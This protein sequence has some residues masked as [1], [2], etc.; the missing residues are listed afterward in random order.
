[1]EGTRRSRYPPSRD[2]LFPQGG[3]RR[4]FESV[5]VAKIAVVCGACGATRVGRQGRRV[6]GRRNENGPRCAERAGGDTGRT[7][8]GRQTE[9]RQATV[10]KN[11]PTGYLSSGG[12]EL[13]RWMQWC[14]GIVVGSVRLAIR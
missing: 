11:D 8:D 13:S 3:W 2:S 7:H 9:G 4:N 1:M 5:R 10:E 12:V 6:R 14:G